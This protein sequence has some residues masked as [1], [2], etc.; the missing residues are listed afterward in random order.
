MRLFIAFLAVFSINLGFSQAYKK[1]AQEKL[2]F[3]E[4]QHM[5][6]DTAVV[7]KFFPGVYGAPIVYKIHLYL[8]T[9]EDLGPRSKANFEMDSFWMGGRASTILYVPK[10]KESNPFGKRKRIHFIGELVFP[11]KGATPPPSINGVEPPKEE[12]VTPPMKMTG[13]LLFRYYV[14]GLPRYVS[15][16]KLKEGRMVYAP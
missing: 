13:E 4:N 2:K 8:T 12:I 11:T 14:N 1:K 15:I 6:V 7:D 10:N 5:I 16:T 9:K 3:P